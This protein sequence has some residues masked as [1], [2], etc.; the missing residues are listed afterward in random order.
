MST[1][2]VIVRIQTPRLTP[3]H[4]NLF[5]QA[6]IHNRFIVL[7]GCPRLF[8]T[9]RNPLDFETR[10]LMVNQQYPYA[11]CLPI[12]DM[13]SDFFWSRQVD[14]KISDIAPFEKT[15]KIYHGRDSFKKHYHGRFETVE[16]KSTLEI[17]ATKFRENVK[18]KGTEDFREGVI[19]STQNRFPM[20]VPCVD[21]LLY[22]KIEDELLFIGGTKEDYENILM[23]GGFVDISDPN[24]WE[25]GRREVK[26][27]V[28][29][30]FSAEYFRKNAKIITQQY[31]NSFRN[32]EDAKLWTT[33][34]ALRVNN[35]YDQQI[36]AGDDLNKVGIFNYSRNPDVIDKEHRALIGEFLEAV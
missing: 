14:A 1:G 16:I 12:Y 24:I 11:I 31:I 27:E 23:P 19:W 34:L 25:A 4:K 18:V 21:V 36:K 33:L 20:V 13:W 6:S 17:S 30:E 8:P 3:A 28:G 10:R 22:S 35:I 26:E 5:D 2:V 32:T 29:L 7:I 9:K 15:V